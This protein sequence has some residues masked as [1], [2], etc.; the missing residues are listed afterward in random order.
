MSKFKMQTK[1]FRYKIE[2][3]TWY[4]TGA[5]ITHKHK[6]KQEQN[7]CLKNRLI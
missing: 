2:L 4:K 6:P 5:Y 1:R 3:E 7:Q